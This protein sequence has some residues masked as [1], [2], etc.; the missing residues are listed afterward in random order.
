MK[1]S[2]K[3][4]AKNIIENNFEYLDEVVESAIVNM[5]EDEDIESENEFILELQ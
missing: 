5:L 2:T 1:E 3:I 4:K